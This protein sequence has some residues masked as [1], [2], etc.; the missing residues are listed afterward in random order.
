M[1]Q[2][3]IKAAIDLLTY[4]LKPDYETIDTGRYLVHPI[5][6]ESSNDIYGHINTPFQLDTTESVSGKAFQSF[7]GEVIRE[8]IS[9]YSLIKINYNFSDFNRAFNIITP[10]TENGYTFMIVKNN[11]QRYILTYKGFSVSKYTLSKGDTNQDVEFLVL[12]ISDTEVLFF[13]N[14]PEDWKYKMYYNKAGNGGLNAP[15]RLFTNV[16]SLY[17][18]NSAIPGYDYIFRIQGEDG[19]GNFTEWSTTHTDGTDAFYVPPYDQES[20]QYMPELEKVNLTSDSFSIVFYPTFEQGL[21]MVGVQ[22]NNGQ[23]IL[24]STDFDRVYANS[25]DDPPPKVAAVLEMHRF[26][27]DSERYPNL[28]NQLGTQDLD[29]RAQLEWDAI[30]GV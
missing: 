1:I 6:E 11:L 26:N 18:F 12:R 8:L 22:Y 30:N 15:S 3:Y 27:N 7:S 13:A 20:N 4:A 2:Y 29:V 28:L 17:I 5:P 9:D 19:N 25:P 16:P 24:R 21:D 14:T 23:E 10:E